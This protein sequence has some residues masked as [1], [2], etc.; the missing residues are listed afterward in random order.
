MLLGNSDASG[1]E[2]QLRGVLGNIVQGVNVNLNNLGALGISTDSDGQLTVDQT[3]L[4][5][6]LAGQVPGVSF[7]DVQRLFGFTAV[8]SNPGVQ[9]VTVGANTRP[10]TTAPYQVNVTQAASQ[11]SITATNTLAASTTIDGTNDAFS[12]SIDGQ[13]FGPLTLCTARIRRNSLP[14]RFRARST[15]SPPRTAARSPS[16]SAAHGWL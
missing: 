7:N 2:Q 14:K 5:A 13:S 10:S 8:S 6:V 1:I 9:F 3:R 12:L 11:A 16:P 15:K 4:N